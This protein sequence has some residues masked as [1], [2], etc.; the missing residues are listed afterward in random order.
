MGCQCLG[1]LT[2]NFGLVFPSW[3][4]SISCHHAE[5]FFFVSVSF[6]HSVLTECLISLQRFWGVVSEALMDCY[7]IFF[8]AV[9]CIL[10]FFQIHCLSQS[11]KD[12]FDYL[13]TP[14]WQSEFRSCFHGCLAAGQRRP[15]N[16]S[17]PLPPKEL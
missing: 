9:M 5:F 3:L 10:H 11:G 2:S 6:T 14:T 16:F 15:Q 13:S 12:Y 17:G 7:I 4:N 8:Q 1:L